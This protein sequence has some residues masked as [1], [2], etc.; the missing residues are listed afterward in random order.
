MASL[1]G[2]EALRVVA[3]PSPS[4][5]ANL[6]KA[7]FSFPSEHCRSL[8]GVAVALEK[9]SVSAWTDKIV[10]LLARCF[11]HRGYEL[12]DARSFPG[13][14]I[15]NVVHSFPGGCLLGH[16]VQGIEVAPSHIY[17]VDVISHGRACSSKEGV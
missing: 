3:L 13:T 11:F 9:V 8:C 4:I 10:H 6:V 2:L 1:F 16:P 7:K 17:D 5:F 15:E 14:K 12:E